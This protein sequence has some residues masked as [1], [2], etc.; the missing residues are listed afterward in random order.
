MGLTTMKLRT[1]Y[2]VS[3]LGMLLV[4]IVFVNTGTQLA[5]LESYSDI[6]SPTLI[7]SFALLGLL[8]LLTKKSIDYVKKRRGKG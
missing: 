6:L 7:G 5:K 4:I 2:W 3:Q 1:F 8:P